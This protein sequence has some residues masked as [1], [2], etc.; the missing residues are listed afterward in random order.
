MWG[1][2][3]SFQKYMD[4]LGKSL[5]KSTTSYNDAMDIL[6]HSIAPTA[7]QLG[8]TTSHDLLTEKNNL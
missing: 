5:N 8:S 4:T 7:Q 2:I 3:E 6:H 1:K